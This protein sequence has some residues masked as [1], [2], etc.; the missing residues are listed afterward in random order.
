[1]T[2]PSPE[3]DKVKPT[4]KTPEQIAIEL[5]KKAKV[6]ESEWKTADAKRKRE[7]AKKVREIGT[8]TVTGTTELK[9]QNLQSQLPELEKKDL[10]EAR[11]VA[12]V[13]VGAVGLTMAAKK[14]SDTIDE[15]WLDKLGV[16]DSI[17][18]WISENA[19][20]KPGED[21]GFFEKMIYKIKMIFLIPLAAAFGV[22]LDKLKWE[23]EDQ[24]EESLAEKTPE[25]QIDYK[26]IIVTQLFSKMFW[27]QFGKNEWCLNNLFSM[28]EFRNKKFSELRSVYD[29]YYKSKNKAWIWKDLW[30]AW[31]KDEQI[32]LAMTSLMASNSNW[33]KL[34]NNVYKHKKPEEQNFEDKSIEEIMTWLH[35][36]MHLM[37]N[38]DRIENLE[39]VLTW[40]IWNA[41]DLH[42]EKN[43]QW[44][45]VMWGWLAEKARSLWLNKN[46]IFYLF[47]RNPSLSKFKDP[48]FINSI[49]SK[50]LNDEDKKII[51]EKIIPFW[52][53]IGNTINTKFNLWEDLTGYF[54]ENSLSLSQVISLY[55]IT[56]GNSDYD[57]MNSLEKTYLYAKIPWIIAEK[58][59]T[60]S[61]SYVAVITKKL[62]IESEIPEEV[63]SILWGIWNSLKDSFVE[64]TSDVIKWIYWFWVKR[65][66]VTTF[67]ALAIL[68]APIAKSRTSL[69]RIITKR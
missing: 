39:D 64:W 38:F 22:D 15:T 3:S 14:L 66:I 49:S 69:Y 13:A 12:V 20:D 31:Y 47:W 32:F 30:I 11:E 2:N 10:K 37:K 68:F 58:D 9:L 36:D 21:D 56:W 61:A 34:I 40:K 67:V 57:K 19:A 6:L 50:E 43:E 44:D 17:K 27:G 45:V 29:K 4:V 16:K 8:D 53:K 5:E 55:I 1:M 33:Y 26:Y 51:T 54:N 52:L 59:V 46:L 60:K 18:K 28:K 48:N 25:Q 35:V 63:K 23:T 24:T 42:A 62:E 41:F 65:P 7:L